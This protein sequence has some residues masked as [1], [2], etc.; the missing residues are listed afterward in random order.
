[1]SVAYKVQLKMPHNVQ[2]ETVAHAAYKWVTVKE[3]LS[4]SQLI[5]GL[6][7]VIR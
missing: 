3:A 5:P 4:I 7:D 2:L 1:M 6:Y